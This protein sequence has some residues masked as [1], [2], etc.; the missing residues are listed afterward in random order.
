[1]LTSTTPIASPLTPLPL[2]PDDA[3]PVCR[4]QKKKAPAG[5]AVAGATASGA[6]AGPAA[7]TSTRTSKAKPRTTTPKAATPA[8]GYAKT[9]S[10]ASTSRTTPGSSAP[11]PGPLA[12]LD[13]PKLSMEEKLLKLLAYLN[14]KWNKELDQKMKEFK[15]SSGSGSSSSAGGLGGFLGKAAG[16]AATAM[17]QLGLTLAALKDPAVRGI[18]RSVAGPAL[19]A[20]ATAA[21][22][23]ALAPVALKYGPE[24]VDAA[25]SVA[26][27]A[28]GSAAKGGTSGATKE[29][30]DGIGSDKDAQLKLME[31]QR[32]I[33]QQK[34]MFSLV[35]NLLRTTHETRM[36]VIQNVR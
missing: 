5:A 30:A 9:A 34:E 18:V 33:D 26:S 15:T 22:Q 1:V 14:D 7:T 28:G 10:T 23:P 25:A 29:S 31:M 17:P 16:F 19:A 24:L 11:K 35:S 13:D 4:T 6:P 3:L 27:S 20:A 2:G 12:F 36:A 8:G 21:G 32:I